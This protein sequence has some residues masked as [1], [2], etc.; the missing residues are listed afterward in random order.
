MPLY[1]TLIT[2]V[3]L[4]LN[5]QLTLRCTDFIGKCKHVTHGNSCLL[6]SLKFGNDF[7]S[8][9][10]LNNANRYFSWSLIKSLISTNSNGKNTICGSKVYVSH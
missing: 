1:K 7:T 4:E 8:L 5:V 3:E 10:G 6:K 2:T 9:Q